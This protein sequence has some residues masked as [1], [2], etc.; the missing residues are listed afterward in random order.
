[1][2]KNHFE[3]YENVR[4]LHKARNSLSE[5][6]DLELINILDLMNLHTELF[7][8]DGIRVNFS[9]K[10]YIRKTFETVSLRVSVEPLILTVFYKIANLPKKYFEIYAEFYSWKVRDF[11]AEDSNTPSSVLSILLNDPD[12]VVR[13][14]ANETLLKI[15]KNV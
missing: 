8:P 4:A 7:V 2:F 15:S 11:I 6:D 3:V 1:M 13:H 12:L 9:R 5:Y 14:H 10:D